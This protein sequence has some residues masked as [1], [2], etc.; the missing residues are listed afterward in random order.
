M[1]EKLKSSLKFVSIALI[2]VLI[3]SMICMSG[4]AANPFGSNSHQSWSNLPD[5]LPPG[6]I[7]YYA[8]SCRN[9]LDSS[10]K[11]VFLK[12]VKGI[13]SSSIAKFNVYESDSFSNP[14]FTAESTNFDVISTYTQASRTEG[15][16][17]G[18]KENPE[19]DYSKIVSVSPL[20]TTI[21]S[22]Q[23]W[24]GKEGAGYV[25]VAEQTTVNYVLTD[26]T[27]DIQEFSVRKVSTSLKVSLNGVDFDSATAQAILNEGK[28]I[29]A[30]LIPESDFSPERWII[31]ATGFDR[32]SA[33]GKL[34]D[35]TIEKK[36]INSSQAWAGGE[37]QL[38]HTF[39]GAVSQTAGSTFYTLKL[40]D[41]S[42]G[43][44]TDILRIKKTVIDNK[45]VSIVVEGI[46][47]M[48]VSYS[49]VVNAECRD[50]MQMADTE[51]NK[52]IISNDS[53][54]KLSDVNNSENGLTVNFNI[55]RNNGSASVTLKLT[56]SG[57][58]SYSFDGLP[59]D[60]FVP[61][62]T[63]SQGAAPIAVDSYRVVVTYEQM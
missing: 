24:D 49:T 45:V 27:S 8:V 54:V 38:R 41:A 18:L 29:N 63:A 36:N 47:N 61:E 42:M 23:T 35:Y 6:T 7:N 39:D 58:L 22:T 60:S 28:T 20:C 3:V 56:E 30:F 12:V 25:N 14:D 51:G 5:A 59:A 40:K 11:T 4:S 21:T 55:G 16:T 48:G 31:T 52:I 26:G 2:L 44:E 46:E 34:I 57:R 19:G 32:H 9:A 10:L 33:D 62:E 53:A 37:T 17:I 43:T 13:D 50:I 1:K 15:W